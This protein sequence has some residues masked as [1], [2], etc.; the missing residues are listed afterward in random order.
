MQNYKKAMFYEKLNSGKV[1]CYLCPHNCVISEEGIGECGVRKNINGELYT[2]NYEKVTSMGLD[3][4]EKKPLK[5]FFKGS[6]ILSIGTFGCN[7]KCSF[8]QN[9]SI[10]QKYPEFINITSEEIVQKAEDLKNQGNIGLAFTY[11]EP[12][13]W[14]EYVYETAALSRENELKNV[15]VTNGFVEKEP[16]TELLPYIDAMN[17]D[18]KAFNEKF[19][20]GIC[21]GGL[22]KVKAAVQIAAKHCHVEITTL[23]IPEYN[24]DPGEIEELAKWIS[25]ISPDIAIHFSRFFPNYNMKNIGPTPIKTLYTAQDIASKYLKNIYLGN[26]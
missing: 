13:I 17:I 24:D 4:I 5:N 6:Q 22:E 2:L 19:Y 15:L 23:I 16:L 18:V 21:K 10:A 20:K 25:S 11:N 12:T 9:W 26:I 8:C 7:F 3:P 14:Y 1:H